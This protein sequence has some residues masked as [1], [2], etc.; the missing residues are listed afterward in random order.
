M[1]STPTALIIRTNCT[2]NVHVLVKKAAH[3]LLN[4]WGF[5]MSPVDGG[6]D[7]AEV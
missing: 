1:Q 5:N 3:W 4:V 6:K 2:I 7:K